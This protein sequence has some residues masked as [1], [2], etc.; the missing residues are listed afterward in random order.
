MK[1][2][3]AVIMV[4]GF[5]TLCFATDE[6]QEPPL[7]F[8][9]DINGQKRALVLDK[10]L[11][12]AGD[13]KNPQVVL[14]AS[15]NRLF[16]YGDIT[17]QY[18]C[19]FT[20][21]AELDGENE[22]KWILSGND[23]K[24]MYFILPGTFSVGSYSQALA[25]RFGGSSTRISDTERMLGGQRLKGKLLFVKLAGTAL[26]MEVYSLS[27]KAGSRM[28][29]FQDSPPD[30]RATSKEGEGALAILSNSFGDTSNKPDT[31]EGK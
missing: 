27:A 20:W 7:K 22:K 10:P 21:E 14:R 6:S 12:L 9:L 18:P 5:C 25:N 23:F 8:T 13:Y 24:I 31:L 30:N 1:R 16:T 15:P 29:V 19:S 2:A 28:L 4:V 11:K 17:F 26:T 3:F